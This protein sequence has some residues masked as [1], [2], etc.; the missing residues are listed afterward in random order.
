V[1]LLEKIVECLNVH[2]M[3]ILFLSFMIFFC[4]FLLFD[5]GKSEKKEIRVCDLMV[6]AVN[7]FVLEN[8]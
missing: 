6:A 5:S 2:V 4:N 3:F 8:V 7:D 1:M